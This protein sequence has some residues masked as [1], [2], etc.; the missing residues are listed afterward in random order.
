MDIVLVQKVDKGAVIEKEV[1]YFRAG[2]HKRSQF[3]GA[4]FC[5]FLGLKKS[6]ALDRRKTLLRECGSFNKTK[7]QH[8]WQHWSK[9]TCARREDSLSTKVARS[10]T[11]RFLHLGFS[12]CSS[13]QDQ[14]TKHPHPQ[15]PGQRRLAQAGHQQYPT[16][17][18]ICPHKAAEDHRQ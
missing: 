2:Q 18:P 1:F 7:Q 13:V 8:T 6:V 17:L 9:T 5:N 3:F 14:C 15:T 12:G 16:L 10:L 11:A 4:G